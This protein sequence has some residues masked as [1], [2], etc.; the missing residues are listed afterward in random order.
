MVRARSSS[1]FVLAGLVFGS[2]GACVLSAPDLGAPL[3]ELRAKQSAQADQIAAAFCA[4]YYACACMETYPIHET[5]EECAEHI[6]EGVL[7]R[8]EQGINDELDYDP[9][10][11]DANLEMLE[12]LGCITDDMVRFD[13]EVAVL[14]ETAMQCR[15][16]DGDL[17]EGDECT[18]LYSA[19]GDECGPGLA[20]D[21]GFHTCF[22][23]SPIA[24]GEPC[25]GQGERA[26]APGLVC[27]YSFQTLTN[28]CLRP[29]DVGQPCTE[30]SYCEADA[31]CDA[32]LTCRRLPRGG[33]PCVDRLGP[34]PCSEDFR[35]N[36]M[37][38]CEPRPSEGEACGRCQLGLECGRENTCEPRRAMICDL[39]LSLP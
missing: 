2:T 28:A 30:G 13:R 23:V 21:D 24:E 37:S 29:A 38:R 35:C 19:R 14:L 16:Y 39:E 32:T 10:C 6:R 17:V 20:C 9:T 5:E 18:P 27:G 33:E 22:A 3:R 26:C 8:L 31:Y 34:D 36:A 15:T 7:A 4:T 11:L 25:D 12:G 1:V